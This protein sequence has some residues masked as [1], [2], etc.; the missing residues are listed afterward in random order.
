MGETTGLYFFSGMMISRR[1]LG[2]L[3]LAGVLLASC[4]QPEAETQAKSAWVAKVGEAAIS[5]DDFKANY[6]FGYA[7][8]RSGPDGREKYLE[9]ILAE[10]LIA[11]SG[12]AARFDTLPEIVERERRLRE[13]LLV[14]TVFQREVID[15]IEITDAEVEEAFRRSLVSF[16][17]RAVPVPS[18]EQALDLRTRIQTEG[19]AQAMGL[20]SEDPRESEAF[21]Q[22]DMTWLDVEP[23]FM[24]SIEGLEMGSVSRPIA[25]RGAW[26]LV[27]VVDIRRKGYSEEEIQI[28][29]EKARQR[30]KLQAMGPAASEYVA[31]MMEPLAVSVCGPAFRAMRDQLAA[32]FATDRPAGNLWSAVQAGSDE[33]SQKLL[34][35]AN[36]TLVRRADGIWTV[37]DFLERWAYTR[38]PLRTASPAEIDASMN[39]AVALTLRDAALMDV[40]GSK[41]IRLTESHEHEIGLWR[42]KWVYRAWVQQTLGLDRSTQIPPDLMARLQDSLQAMRTRY[43][44]EIRQDV[45]DTLSLTDSHI[46]L[47]VYKNSNGRMAYPILDPV[48]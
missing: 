7:H 18:F 9:G 36:D 5:A 43:P 48:W 20:T 39:D 29:F 32:L 23:E 6:E 44:V 41:G 33:A 1:L 28:G 10:Q 40:A 37:G 46:T 22:K 30:L 21:L 15:P 16:D 13:E 17:L 19:F 27:E 2:G 38:Y 25:H 4:S 45:L 31:R 34:A 3:G 26:Y 24:Q 42:D 8:L 11:Q 47:M 14:E 12:Y 35:M